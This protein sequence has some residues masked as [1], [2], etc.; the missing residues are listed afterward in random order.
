MALVQSLAVIFN[1]SNT[2][3]SN[4]FADVS[5]GAV[6]LEGIGVGTHFK[7]AKFVRNAAH[8]G[9]GVYSTGSGT[10]VTLDNNKK[11]HNNPTMFDGCSF[12]Y[13]LAFATGGAVDT[14]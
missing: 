11:Q 14:A 13:N 12:V 7:H 3:F 1:S 2:M 5:G 9:G 8:V 10:T 4:N 6:Y